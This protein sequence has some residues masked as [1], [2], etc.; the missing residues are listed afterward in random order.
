MKSFR[1]ERIGEQVR[2]EM[3]DLLLRG[4][5]DS[6]IHAGMVS[7][8]EVEVTGDLRHC[9]IYVSI[10]GDSQAQIA[11]MAGLNSAA[12]FVRGELG[13]RIRLRYTPEVHFEQDTSLERGDRMMTLLNQLKKDP[14]LEEPAP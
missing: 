12:G 2:K 5:K 1:T 7:I 14:P 9:T 6:R 10:Y 4:L 13:R 8:T 3:S 11:A